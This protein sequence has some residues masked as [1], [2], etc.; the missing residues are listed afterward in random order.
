MFTFFSLCET[1]I[2][3][4]HIPSCQSWYKSHLTRV[5]W[6]VFRVN[7]SRSLNS[8][9]HGVLVNYWFSSPQA[10]GFGTRAL[11]P[12]WEADCNNP[13]SSS[14]LPR[15]SYSCPFVPPIIISRD[16]IRHFK[17]AQSLESFLLFC[18]AFPSVIDCA[19]QHANVLDAVAPYIITWLI[20][21]DGRLFNGT[22]HCFH[23]GTPVTFQALSE[24]DRK[25]WMEAMDGKEPVSSLLVSSRQGTF[26]TWM[27]P[28]SEFFLLAAVRQVCSLT[29]M[30][31]RRYAVSQALS[32]SSLQIKSSF[33]LISVTSHRQLS[34]RPLWNA[35]RPYFGK[36]RRCFRGANKAST[37]ELPNFHKLHV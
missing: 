27:Y 36:I 2:V 31:Q 34:P 18:L 15:L 14:F 30:L 26:C 22:F 4:W 32:R 12:L 24:G 1:R 6:R 29:K 19:V 28:C 16:L 20:I 21:P 25:L 13:M 35:Y 5:F 17:D 33:W 37:P 3:H 11:L 8:W 7:Y 9:V 23:R 10:A